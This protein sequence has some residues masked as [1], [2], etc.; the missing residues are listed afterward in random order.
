[1]FEIIYWGYFLNHFEMAETD[2]DLMIWIKTAHKST[3]FSLLIPV[4]AIHN[5]SIM[6]SGAM[7][8]KLP[9]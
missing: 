7:N 2:L 3:A 5:S 6:T 8:A 1:M 4:N 9:L